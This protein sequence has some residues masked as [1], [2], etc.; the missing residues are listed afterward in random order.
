VLVFSCAAP[1]RSSTHSTTFATTRAVEAKRTASC[2]PETLFGSIG[3]SCGTRPGRSSCAAKSPEQTKSPRRRWENHGRKH[4]QSNEC[5]RALEPL[6]LDRLLV[7][8]DVHGFFCAITA[9][10][11]ASTGTLSPHRERQCGNQQDA[12]NTVTNSFR[13]VI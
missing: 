8:L 10:D 9:K 12:H 7:G 2:N 6:L 11:S 4:G 1:I 13:D 5:C 3:T